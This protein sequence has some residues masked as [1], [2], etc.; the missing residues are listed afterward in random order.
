[1][2]RTKVRML[3]ATVAALALMVG[4][5]SAIAANGSGGKDLKQAAAQ[6]S[7][8]ASFEAAVA[9]NL[10]TTTA[11]LERGGQGRGEGQH[12]RRHSLPTTSRRPRRR[13]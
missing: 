5:G 9:K 8:R 13:R 4:V 2:R 1:M 11:K 7:G 10:G 6:I 3:F 12:R